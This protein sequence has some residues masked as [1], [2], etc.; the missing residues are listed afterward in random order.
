MKLKSM[1]GTRTEASSFAIALKPP[2]RSWREASLYLT[3]SSVD[4]KTTLN[5]RNAGV[6]SA[7]IAGQ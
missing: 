7:S 3:G 6:H 5:S 4:L 1:E 2:N